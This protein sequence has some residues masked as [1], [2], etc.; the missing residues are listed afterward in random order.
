MGNILTYI[1]NWIHNVEAMDGTFILTLKWRWS[2]QYKSDF[3]RDFYSEMIMM[4][5]IW[6]FTPHSI[7]IQIQIQNVFIVLL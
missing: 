3:S 5:T 2:E 1:N 4:M 7:Q 6:L